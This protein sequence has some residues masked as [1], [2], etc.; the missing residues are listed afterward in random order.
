MKLWVAY[1]MTTAIM[2]EVGLG[3]SRAQ[4]L[5]VVNDASASAT[6]ITQMQQAA[7]D[8]VNGPVTQAYPFTTPIT[9]WS[10]SQGWTVTLIAAG[11]WPCTGVYPSEVCTIQNGGAC[12]CW[13]LHGS[14]SNLPPQAFVRWPDGTD[15]ETLQQGEYLFSHEVIEMMVDPNGTH[16]EICD[17]E[18]WVTEPLDGVTVASFLVPGTGAWTPPTAAPPIPTTQPTPQPDP[19]PTPQPD[20]PPTSQ[21]DPPPTPQP[22][23]RAWNGSFIHRSRARHHHH[24]R[25]RSRT[26][27]RE[28]ELRLRQ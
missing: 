4:T 10:D 19:P 25:H 11:Q 6:V 27:A 13:G 16:P 22:D 7:T 2:F 20:P 5:N 17:P 8:E 23:P 1:L 12:A 21:A 26:A 14:T 3:I 28:L 18:N 9:G 24:H 15:Q